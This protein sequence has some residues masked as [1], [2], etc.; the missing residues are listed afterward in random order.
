M[1]RSDTCPHHYSDVPV[2]EKLPSAPSGSTIPLQQNS[3]DQQPNFS[4]RE[5]ARARKKKMIFRAKKNRRRVDVAKKTAE[6]KAVATSLAPTIFRILASVVALVAIG[7]GAWACLQWAR[8]SERFAIT[9]ITIDGNS[10]ASDGELS[11]LGGLTPGLNLVAFD[12][13]AA[14][15]AIGT[16]AWVKAVRVTRRFPRGLE[17]QVTEHKPAAMVSLGDLYLLDEDGEPFKRVGPSDAL[18][19]PIVT[20]IERDDYVAR[21]DDTVLRLTRALALAQT[22]ASS[23]AGRSAPLSEVHLD[24][25]GVTLVTANGQHVQLGDGAW[26]EKLERLERVRQELSSRALAPSVIRLDNRARPS[27]VTVSLQTNTPVIPPERGG[28]P[29]K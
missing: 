27:W 23:T 3:P 1:N 4:S 10:H 13:P 20:V 11:R 25:E 7:Y 8:Q 5:S 18:D 17:V 16:H 9:G 28:R 21:H 24:Q 6:I 22:Y 15:R 12:A 26:P 14:E 19:L 2:D 29:A